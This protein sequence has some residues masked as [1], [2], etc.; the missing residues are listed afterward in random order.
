MNGDKEREVLI[1][2]DGIDSIPTDK[3]ELETDV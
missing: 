2:K 1:N 3:Q